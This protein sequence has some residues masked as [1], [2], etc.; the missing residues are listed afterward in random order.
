VA[1]IEEDKYQ[2][3]ENDWL[4]CMERIGRKETAYFEQD[5]VGYTTQIIELGCRR[6]IMVWVYAELKRHKKL[7]PIEKLDKDIKKQMWAFVLEIC[8]GKNAETKTMIEIAKTFYVIE[9]YLNEYNFKK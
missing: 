1:Q 6:G 2:K 9:Y 7:E 5:N 8:N 3:A 4:A